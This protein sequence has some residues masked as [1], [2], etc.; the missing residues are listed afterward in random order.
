MNTRKVTHFT[1]IMFVIGASCLFLQSANAT[2]LFSDGFDYTAGNGLSGSGGW[3]GGGATALSINSGNLTYPGLAD[4][5]PSGNNLKLTSGLTASTDYTNF[6]GSAVT[7]GTIYFSFLLSPTALP[8]AN[9]EL[10]DLL[11]AGSTGLAGSSAPLGI[12]VG[13]QTANVQYKIG[14]RHG[15]S[16]ATY[17]TGG[18]ATLNSTNLIVAAY[19][20]ND[21]A[22]NDTVS[23]WVNPTPGGSQPTAD[24]S[25]GNALLADAANLQVLGI[26]AQS[27]AVTQGNWLFDAFRVGDAWADVVPIPEPSTFAL[28]GAGLG[29]MIAMIRR[30]RS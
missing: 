30:R 5:S 8:T 4:T 14:V 10:M 11:P 13:Q 29:L 26:K 22:A 9:Q 21:G 27:P 23:L 28:A 2:M 6:N 18:W 17:A 12:Y 24:V 16:G 1:R 7:S 3:L 25:F 20:F 15:L 19:T